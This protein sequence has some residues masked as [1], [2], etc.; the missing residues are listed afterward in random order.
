MMEQAN[1]PGY[2]IVRELG[3][4]GMGTVYLAVQESLGREVALKLMSPQFAADAMATERF[5]REG[6]IAARLAHRHIVSVYDVGVHAGQPYLAM[7]YMAGGAISTSALHAPSAV[8]QIVRE[9]ALALDHA[10]DEGVIHRD[11]K[12]ENILRRKDGSHA[13]ADFGIARSLHTDAVADPALTREGTT[14]GTPYYMSPEQLQA[15]PL[16]GRSDL[17]SLGVVFYQLLMGRLPYSGTGD[18]PVGMQHI[19]SPVPRLPEEL[20]RHQPLIDALMAKSPNQRP[21]SGAELAKRIEAIQTNPSVAVMT[22][23]MPAWSPAN[24]KPWIVAAGLIVALAG[25]G[26]FL[27]L[28][29]QSAPTPVPASAARAGS[30]ALADALKTTERSIAVLP[31]VNASK[32]PEQQFFSDGL[33]EN[34]IDTLSRFDGLKVIGRMSSFQFRDDKGD[35]AVIGAKLG[36]A[37]LLGGSVQRAGD[38]VRIS[39]SLVKAADGS[40]LWA[41]H[42]DRPYKDL[43]ALQDEITNAV[44]GALQAKLLSPEAAARQDDRP[45]SGN[46]EAYNAYLQG[47]KHWHDEEFSKAAESMTQ[48]VQL[49]P[50]YAMAW[51]QLSGSWSTVSTFWDKSPEAASEH[52]RI[53]RLAADKALQLAPELGPAHAAL[54]YLKV[55]HLDHQGAL[56]GC[57]RAVQLA[58]K[59]GTVLNGCG[60]LFAQ[61]GKLGEAIALRARLLSTEPLY[62][63]N[64]LQYANLLMA[65]GR[66]DEAEKYLRTAENLP[67]TNPKWRPKI[68]FSRM[69]DAMMRGDAKA[70]MGIAAELPAENR[71]LY[72]ALAAQAGPDRATADAA[73]ANALANKNRADTN[74]YLIAQIYALRGD[75]GHAMEWLQRASTGDFIFLPTD[76][77]IMNLRDDPGFIAFCQKIG[78]PPPSEVETL[79]IDQIRASSVAKS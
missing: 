71:E 8:L 66:T 60:Y 31:L 73:L 26:G 67:Q 46:I 64:Y 23:A 10:H 42:Y 44:A 47:L 33:S 65:A 77:I 1:I 3:R 48:A 29:H 18:M 22:Q 32:D 17:Y 53:A 70:A 24:R 19:H 63:I 11:L 49:D 16:D 35:S 25:V 21:A 45:P 41:E 7:E 76:P 75:A 40:T 6:R 34:L 39:A 9:I 56:T 68:V 50:G 2:R 72:T 59:D 52:M 55:Y 61:V 74:P 27:A 20:D 54:A 28:T 13:L 58:P 57:R 69:V 30:S 12:P 36:A 51:A 14:I 43:F 5:L 37:Y 4:G 62:T 78:L 15:Q 79:S 38:L